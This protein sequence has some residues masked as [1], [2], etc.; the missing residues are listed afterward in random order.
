ML[1]SAEWR[2][3]AERSV[4]IIIIYFPIYFGFRKLEIDA[5]TSTTDTYDQE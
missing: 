1:L 3:L 4:F 5:L 2:V